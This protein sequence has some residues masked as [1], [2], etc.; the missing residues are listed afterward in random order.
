MNDSTGFPG[1]LQSVYNVKGQAMRLLKPDVVLLVFLFL[2]LGLSPL[3][4]QAEPAK[5]P[6]EEIS[7]ES[8]RLYFEAIT[9]IRKRTLPPLQNVQIVRG[10]LKAY[11]R[12]LDPF[13]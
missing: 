12:S 1:I 13:S 11:V 6:P 4:A 7:D 8:I 2:W 9:Q 3:G 5:A 10:T